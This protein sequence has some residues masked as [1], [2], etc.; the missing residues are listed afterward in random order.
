M[1]WNR[2]WA[3]CGLF[4][5]HNIILLTPYGASNSIYWLCTI[6]S[7][8]KYHWTGQ[9][10]HFVLYV[11][12]HCARNSFEL[13]RNFE[14]QSSILAQLKRLEIDNNCARAIEREKHPWK[15]WDDHFQSMKIHDA[16]YIVHHLRQRITRAMLDYIIRSILFM[17]IVIFLP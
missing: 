14:I 17:R 6:V 9:K 10:H 3:V 2:E 15:C 8:F 5:A 1:V 16:L 7:K 13:P 12:R 4:A 11:L